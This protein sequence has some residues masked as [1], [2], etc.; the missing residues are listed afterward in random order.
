MYVTILHKEQTIQ[1]LCD[2]FS[3]YPLHV[4]GSIPMS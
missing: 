4:F 2:T 1:Y 3:Y